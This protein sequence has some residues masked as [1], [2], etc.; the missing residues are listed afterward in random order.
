MQPDFSARLNLGSALWKKHELEGA[1]YEFL[2]PLPDM[3]ARRPRCA[4]APCWGRRRLNEGLAA[5]RKA[6]ELLPQ[7]AEA[8]F[9]A[10]WR[11]QKAATWPGRPGVSPG[12][13][14]TPSWV[15][16]QLNLG[17]ALRQ[18]GDSGRLGSPEKRREIE[19]VKTR[20]LLPTRGLHTPWTGQLPEAE[21]E[22]RRS[23]SSQANNAQAY[24]IL[25]Q[26]L[27]Q[28]GKHA[29]SVAAFAEVERL[30]HA[31]AD[32]AQAVTQYNLGMQELGKGDLNAS[33]DAFKAALTRWPNL[34]Q[35]HTNLGGVLLKLGD[36][37]GAI[38]QLRAAIDLNPDEAR[39][40]FNL[41]LALG[42]DGD[43]EGAKKALERARQL[44]PQI[45][46]PEAK[47]ILEKAVH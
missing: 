39:A 14:S 3:E 13:N 1:E 38:G 7:D 22:L 44:D 34:A 15:D 45:E 35:G 17:I 21:A 9:L 24:Y 10:G 47:Q 40:Y 31:S 33:R 28:M 8:H 27:E 18:S 19:F 23:I 12:P 41:S 29:D 4:L 30:H 25:G 2:A 11:L 42:K 36:I 5:Q 37:K 16:A 32:Y 26:T 43:T 46:V 20:R 6:V